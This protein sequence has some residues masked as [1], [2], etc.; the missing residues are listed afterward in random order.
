M[1]LSCLSL[2]EGNDTVHCAALLINA[3]F[4]SV[5]CTLQRW[6]QSMVKKEAEQNQS[7][8]VLLMQKT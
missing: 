7:F 8:S 2:S 3:N 4:G 6:R 1:L 5:A